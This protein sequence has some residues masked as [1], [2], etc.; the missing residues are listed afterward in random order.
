M[1]CMSKNLVGAERST[2][3]GL[4]GHRDQHFH[5]LLQHHT[6]YGLRQRIP[7]K[8]LR[9]YVKVATEESKRVSYADSSPTLREPIPHTVVS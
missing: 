6:V 8:K 1:R 9:G 4:F 3:R 7:R 5:V 2:Q